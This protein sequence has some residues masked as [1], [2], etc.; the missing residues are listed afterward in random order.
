[1]VVTNKDFTEEA[2]LLG[3]ADGVHMR[4]RAD[5]AL[6]LGRLPRGRGI[7]GDRET[8]AGKAPGSFTP[9]R[10]RRRPVGAPPGP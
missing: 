5:L 9:V 8:G 4:S 1:M 6:E 2:V 7:H 3:H 10:T